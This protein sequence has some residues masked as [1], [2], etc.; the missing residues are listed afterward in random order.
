MQEN[1]GIILHRGF[2]AL[3]IIDPQLAKRQ[4]RPAE[5]VQNVRTRT[6]P[7]AD[8]DKADLAVGAHHVTADTLR[9]LD[10]PVGV[11]SSDD[12]TSDD[13]DNLAAYS[14]GNI[15]VDPLNRKAGSRLMARKVL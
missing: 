1:C 11:Y 4:R 9:T 5:L 2:L 12:S 3:A 14:S 15:A 8:L 6:A 7:V 13:I 10:D